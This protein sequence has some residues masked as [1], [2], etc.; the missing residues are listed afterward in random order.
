MAPIGHVSRVR[1]IAGFAAVLALLAGCTAHTDPATNITATTATLNGTVTIGANDQGGEY[2]FE[3]SSDAGAIWTQERNHH[4][5]G[6]QTCT[7]RGS[8]A[9][10]RPQA[11][12][13]DISGLSPDTRYIFRIAGRI[14]DSPVVYADSNWSSKQEP[15]PPYEYDD[16]TTQLNVTAP[17]ILSPRAGDASARRFLL[18]AQAQSSLASASFE[19]RR[20]DTDPWRTI[21]LADIY[22]GAGQQLQAW[23]AQLDQNG[24]TPLLTWD[25]WKTLGSEGLVQLRARFNDGT[26]GWV[27]SEVVKVTLTRSNSDVNDATA[28]IGPGTVDLLTGN[29]S[30]TSTDV[31]I[32]APSTD[33]TA[34]RTY[35]SRQAN[36]NANGPLGPGW[37][38]S[39]PVPSAASAYENLI[40][41]A[42]SGP[43]AAGSA[44][45][46]ASTG[47]IAWQGAG[48]ASGGQ[49]GG[50]AATNAHNE[51]SHYLKA[52]NFGFS[53]PSGATIKGIKVEVA[54]TQDG[55]G[56]VIDFANAGSDA[57]TN[58]QAGA[59][60]VKG[61]AVSGDGKG[62]IEGWPTGPTATWV[63]YG[64]K[65]DTWGLSWTP[66]DIN[67][68]DFGFALSVLGWGKTFGW[69][70]V[71][72]LR[73]TVYYS[74]PG[75]DAS[76]VLTQTDGMQEHF[77][78]NALDGSYTPETG[79]PKMTL[80]DSGDDY[81]LDD[82]LGDK[83]T[84]SS[85]TGDGSYVPV[86]VDQPG[87]ANETTMRWAAVNGVARITNVVAPPPTGVSC[88]GTH[89]QSTP[90]C[91][92]LGFDYAN[93]TTATGGAANQWGD[94]AGRLKD[95]NFVA[96]DPAGNV[97][98]TVPV[99]QYSY[100][101]TG[102]LRAAWDPRVSPALRTTYAYDASG[103]LNQ[104]TPPGLAPWSFAYATTPDDAGLGRLKS[105]TR[106]AV[107]LPTETTTLAYDV[108][109]SGG[110]A[111]Y[112]MNPQAV[113][114]WGQ[115]DDPTDGTAIFPP[116]HVP[117]SPPSSFA[118][119]L[120]VYMNAKAQQVNVA[121][122]GGRIGMTEHNTTGQ[123]VRELD[124]ANRYRALQSSDPLARAQQLDTENTYNADGLQLLQTLEPLHAVVLDDGTS[125]QARQKTVMSY[126]KDAPGG[127]PF[128]LVTTSTEG[129]YIPSSGGAF[130]DQRVTSYGY[131]T[132][133]DAQGWV[134]RQPTTTTVDPGGLNIIRIARYDTATGMPVWETQ[135]NVQGASRAGAGWTVIDYYTA[136][137]SGQ[138]PGKPWFANLPCRR[139]P[140][141]QPSS[142]PTV[143]SST[144]D[145]NMLDQATVRSDVSG[146]T[147]RMTSSTYDAAGRS[148]GS[149][150]AGPGASVPNVV[151]S[152]NA[153]TGLLEKSSAS[154]DGTPRD[155]VRE[156]DAYGHP[157]FYLDAD[158]AVTTAK[159]DAL[160]RATS[161]SDKKGT[162]TFTY[163]DL[164]GDLNALNASGV[165]VFTGSYDADG[166]LVTERLPDGV[167][168]TTTYDESG[169]RTGLAYDNC[170]A[171]CRAMLSF[172]SSD[173]V[174]D[175]MV[176]EN[177][178]GT[179]QGSRQQSFGYDRAGRL[180]FAKEVL[181]ASCTVDS[182]GYDV[183][184]NRT[185]SAHVTYTDS[186][187]TAGGATTNKQFSHDDADRINNAGYQYDELGR[188]LTV[189]GADAGKDLAATYYAN[190]LARGITQDGVT[191][192][193][194]L[195]P[196]MRTRLRSTTAAADEVQHFSDDTNGPRWTETPSNG[197]WTRL[198]AGISGLLEATQ[199]GTA[200]G[201]T[202]TTFQLSDLQGSVVGQVNATGTPQLQ[203]TPLYDE[204]G[205]PRMP[206]NASRYGWLGG[207]DVAAETSSGVVAMGARLYMPTLGR[208]LQMD[209]V[210][211]GSANAYDYANQD[212]LNQFDLAG[213]KPH[214]HNAHGRSLGDTL[215]DLGGWVKGNVKKGVKAACATVARPQCNVASDAAKAGKWAYK[216]VPGI[217]KNGIN[218]VKNL[219]HGAPKPVKA[220]LIGVG[221]HLAGLGLVAI[222]GGEVGAG[223]IAQQVVDG[224]VQGAGD[225]IEHGGSDGGDSGPIII[226]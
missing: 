51:Y 188:T 138:C 191:R 76:V 131:D 101:N 163:D 20:A 78:R 164:T 200:T 183:D 83:T 211:G 214:K 204:F 32:D 130:V 72:S 96:Y 89:L 85:L 2:W 41:G 8:G 16:F 139:S 75:S 104:M 53:I 224:C 179:M 194:G 180:T 135:P 50:M 189:P 48:N 105:I 210:P 151:V 134:L 30:L 185:A 31:S 82:N 45:D 40:G 161:V 21:P 201:P 225:Q 114:T 175:Q 127:G 111:P 119:A 133:G 7:Y 222:L 54:K 172:T 86:K 196:D 117:A 106:A 46:D 33:L 60:I 93:A 108:P 146:S 44:V 71:D 73:A 5:W 49:D 34:T 14:C 156:F 197:G 103:V 169:M 122:P 88:D 55:D 24:K 223:E 177:T 58:I 145:Y 202:S 176:T 95:I 203:Q 216:H 217:A 129:A 19:F 218:W 207:H 150:V 220:C 87:S 70:Y 12:H 57:T 178:T 226:I 47:S 123:V 99:Q 36:K 77:K 153:G 209:P 10:G 110:A 208:F 125:V 28:P 11:I 102:R 38:L 59:R 190:D 107:G 128:N 26:G 158:G 84:F 157:S 43:R 42:V 29:L 9:E 186:A 168:A 17:T 199:Q 120:V 206:P 213:T 69:A 52:T 173:S 112:Q 193:F 219:W 3:W 64:S 118:S 80:S 170:S 182:Y 27:A 160:D 68:S 136:D 195:D 18:Q 155:I 215:G 132:W 90:G 140:A 39:V 113:G 97:M 98:R 141:E 22:T 37:R 15:D 81:V 109:L 35:L 25:A 4:K 62:R 162:R 212:P 124:A 74:P 61:G 142:G 100:D 65:S 66:A 159:Y 13:E 148:T 23:P 91:R 152:Y 92:S 198:I 137:G 171:A 6:S 121:A 192:T 147:T 154:I 79:L 115:Q 149:T 187:C 221:E 181:G 167:R 205:T 174:H 67:S 1:K 165:G 56:T 63:G 166:R 143:P 116:N 144:F 184:S 94:Y 126:D